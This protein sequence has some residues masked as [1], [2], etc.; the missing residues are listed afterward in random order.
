MLMGV[1]LLDDR[2]AG[3]MEKPDRHL[4]LLFL[5]VVVLLTEPDSSL[6]QAVKQV[7]C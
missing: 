6:P 3:C 7:N 5:V 4:S 1:Q 2:P